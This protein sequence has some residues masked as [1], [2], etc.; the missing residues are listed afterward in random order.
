MMSPTG[1]ADYLQYDSFFI[2]FT[3]SGKENRK[4]LEHFHDTFELAFFIRADIHIF[5][6]DTKYDIRDGDWLLIHPYD[7]HSIFYNPNHD[8]SRYVLQFK[9]SFIREL[10]A[11][12]GME[13]R[14]EAIQQKRNKRVRLDL[15]QRLKVEALYRTILELYT[16]QQQLHATSSH[17]PIASAEPELKL[18]LTL[19]LLEYEKLCSSSSSVRRIRSAEEPVQEMIAYLD[20]HYREPVQ[21]AD[22]E[23]HIGKSKFTL[24]RLFSQTTQFTVVEYL[25]YKRIIEAQKRLILTDQPIFDIA[26]D[27]GFHNAQHFYRIFKKI[28]GKTPLQ[29]RKGRV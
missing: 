11:V 3:D 14:F 13:D 22:L 1:D 24:C 21:L 7:I 18:Q 26:L 27:C 15:G 8:Y 20:E 28:C 2:D 17:H 19:L 25:Q 5:V 6:K 9:S 12:L 23:R 10:L 29:Y 4:P 16:Q